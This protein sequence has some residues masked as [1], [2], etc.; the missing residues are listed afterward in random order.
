MKSFAVLCLLGQIDARAFLDN[1]MVQ[2]DLKSGM[3]LGSLESAY[4]AQKQ[5]MK[6]RAFK[7]DEG[8]LGVVDASSYVKAERDAIEEQQVN[9]EFAQSPKVP[10]S[11]QVLAEK[12]VAHKSKK[13]EEL[14]T[15]PNTDNVERS[16]IAQIA[17]KFEEESREFEAQDKNMYIEGTNGKLRLRHASD[18]YAEVADK[19]K[20]EEKNS[21]K[22]LAQL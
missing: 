4:L 18:G 9:I 5:I 3:S 11:I 15:I 2:L 19:K 12:K 22:I 16:N 13:E 17:S 6:Q 7:W 14:P 20:F 8:V 21:A 1:D 10:E